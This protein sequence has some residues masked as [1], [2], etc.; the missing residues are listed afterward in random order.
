MT[1]SVVIPVYNHQRYV[2][3]TLLSVLAAREVDEVLVMDDGSSD[4]SA[5]ILE[6]F[7]KQGRP[8]V[9]NCTSVPRNNI[10][11]PACLNHLC[12]K[13]SGEWIAVLNS[14]DHFVPGRFFHARQAMR[15]DPGDFLFGQMMLMDSEG[16]VF[17]EKR[18]PYDPEYPLP[19]WI[20]TK[21]LHDRGNCID[22]LANQNFIATTG[23]M[24]FTKKLWKMVGGFSD[25]RYVHD[26]DFALRACIQGRSRFIPFPLTSYRLHPSNTIKESTEKVDAEIVRMFERLIDDFPH[27]MKRPGFRISLAENRHIANPTALLKRHQTSLR[28]PQACRIA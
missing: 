23:N 6:A 15:T 18:V 17:A 13:A 11:A 19:D 4:A 9:I 20:V 25:Y 24:I 2:L 14:D 28:S 7:G 12:A 26:W 16:L 8:R 5:M 10:G 22:L 27:L 3:S 21:D 1:F